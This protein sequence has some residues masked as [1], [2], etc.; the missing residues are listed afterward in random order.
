M[1][2]HQSSAVNGRKREILVS[3]PP[4]NQQEKKRLKMD[5]K[6]VQQQQPNF[7]CLYNGAN[8]GS[9]NLGGGNQ[10]TARKLVIKNL[11]A[12]PTLPSDFV[13]KSLE[14]LRR[15]TLAIQ[16][17][18]P[19][20]D[21]TLEELYQA[22]ETLCAHDAAQRVYADLK[23]LVEAHVE[24]VREFLTPGGESLDKLIFMKKMNAS[25]T[26]HCRQMIMTRSIFLFLDRTYVLQNPSVL[27]I[28]EMGLDTFRR[29]VLTH[30]AV[31]T[32]T[33][34]GILMLIE[35]ERHGDMV[36]R[37]LLKSLLRMLSDLQIYKE[38]DVP[39]YL[40]HVE[41]R[42][43]EENER[44]I[45]YLDIS[46]KWQLIHTVEKQ[47][48][49]EHMTTIL[50]KGL[51]TLLEENRKLKMCEF[52]KKRGKVLVVNPEKDK[53][54]VQELLDFKDKLDTIM[55]E[56]FT[57]NDQF[58]VGMKEAFET[59]INIRQNKPAE[60]IAKFVDSKLKAGNKEASEEELEKL[61]DKIMVIFRFIH[62][63]D[64]FEAFYKKDLAKRLL[65]GKSASVDSEKSMLSKLKAECGAGF[66]SKLEGM[67]K[68]ME[69]S[70]DINIAYRQHLEGLKSANNKIDMTV[71]VLSMAYWP[72]YQPMEVTMPSEMAKYQELF[73]KF[74]HAKYSGRKLQWQPNLGHAVLKANFKSGHKELRVSLFQTLVLLLF[75]YADELP[76]A[77]IKVSSNIEDG[78]LRRTLQSLACGKIRVLKKLP[79]GKDVMDADKF[80][81]N[82]EFTHQLCHIKINQVQ[83]KETNDEQKATEERVFQDRQY[84]IDAAV[85]RIMKMRKTIFHNLL[86]TELYNQLKFPVKPPDLKKR[87]ESLIDRDYMERD[88][89]NTNQYNYVA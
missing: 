28:W 16:T 86:I 4:S 77:E 43:K 23:A 70:R 64:V 65:V 36:D 84:Q 49:S 14:K 1:H 53:T 71:N 85:V 56:C 7:S 37:S 35:Q 74:Y 40:S 13:S 58:V 41:K 73:K 20:R 33:V 27:S 44:F 54:M 25:W 75:N 24:T 50:T 82:K 79:K 60:L 87:I 72:T 17:S 52:V 9:K 5:S 22:V 10:A 39:E 8:G 67:F 48:I 81:F 38:A 80:Y 2:H 89:D 68:D 78:E 12:Q 69:L 47:L 6:G 66:T 51:D 61:L 59:F 57:G 88:K 30:P 21:A 18:E 3:S 31:Q 26:S 42:L 29:Y 34:D 76:F 11:K 46:T 62:G 15:A 55:S 19:I 63:K 32:R 83:M 45:H